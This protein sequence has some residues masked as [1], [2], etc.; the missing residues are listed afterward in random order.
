MHTIKPRNPLACAAILKK[1]G[2]HGRSRSGLR[3]SQKQSLW[4]E[5]D[6]WREENEQRRVDAALGQNADEA[7]L[8]GKSPKATGHHPMACC[9][10]A[11]AHTLTIQ[12]IPPTQGHK[13]GR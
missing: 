12:H 13:A 3:Q 11:F 10:W 7:F 5:L 6:D 4:S 1:G 2:A 9:F 8:T